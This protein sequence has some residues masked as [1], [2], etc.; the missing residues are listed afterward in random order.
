MWK[1][2]PVCSIIFRH[3]NENEGLC[4]KCEYIFVVLRAHFPDA[5]DKERYEKPFFLMQ[6]LSKTNGAH[7][8]YY[9]LNFKSFSVGL[10]MNIWISKWQNCSKSG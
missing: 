10:F 9:F 8:I 2:L 5:F 6:I 4:A 1:P 7:P 3:T